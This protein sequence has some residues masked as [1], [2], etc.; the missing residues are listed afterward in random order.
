[1]KIQTEIS[2]NASISTTYDAFR[3]LYVWLEILPDVS[4]I[5]IL[6]D[7]K[8][9]QEFLMRVVRPAGEETIR[10]IRFCAMDESINLFQPTPPPGFKKM[11]G[12]WKFERS[13]QQTKVLVHREFE[14]LS[15]NIL[16]YE[17]KATQ[18]FQYLQTNL[19][20]F[21][22]HLEKPNENTSGNHYCS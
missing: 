20:I 7:D 19:G 21:K 12:T 16:D 17:T 3:D 15:D 5:D 1:M 22:Q 11:V 13:D 4:G 18:M 10:G 8:K 6:Y 2:I 14:L 9:H